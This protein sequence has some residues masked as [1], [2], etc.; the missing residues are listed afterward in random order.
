M[1]KRSS[2]RSKSNDAEATQ[3]AAASDEVAAATAE[4][5]ELDSDA[6]AEAELETEDDPEAADAE[7]S[8]AE[9][10][11]GADSDADGDGE[12]APESEGKPQA[13]RIGTGDALDDDELESSI[14]ALLFVSPEPVSIGRLLQLLDYPRRGRIEEALEGLGRR[15]VTAGLPFVVRPL[16]GGWR[17]L[18]SPEVS[19]VVT[20]LGKSR[21]TEKL[22]PA[23]L[24]TLAIIAYRQPTTKAEVEAIR[25]VQA[26]A[27]LR[28]LVDRGLVRVAGRS[29][30]PGG[31]LE[32]GTTPEFLDR[33]GLGAIEDLP[34]DGELLEG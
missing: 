17:L 6:E 34:R 3:P 21:K 24:E 29:D 10:E 33:F 31:A 28:A 22:S 20:R 7:S 18:T 4:V 1:A 5:E 30:Q 23:A 11:A 19:D 14:A 8:E 2:K 16:A 9:V 25:G 15:F 27:V 32:Y 26:G 13:E 12:A